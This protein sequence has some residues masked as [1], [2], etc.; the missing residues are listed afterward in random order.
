MVSTT[1]RIYNWLWEKWRL[2]RWIN[3]GWSFL[4]QSGGKIGVITREI[5]C[6]QWE[7]LSIA[8]SKHHLIT[9]NIPSVKYF[10]NHLSNYAKTST[11]LRLVN[12]SE[13]SP[14]P[15]L[16]IVTNIHF[17]LIKQNLVKNP[18]WWEADQTSWLFTKCGGLE[19]GTTNHK[20]ILWQGGGFE[21][22]TSESQI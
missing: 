17:T 19:S 20:S 21:F 18:Y 5:V 7:Q 22:R 16:G 1:N 2:T 14:W 9:K 8:I 10:Y 13:Y 15:H 6:W 12:I 3:V 11:R 4:C